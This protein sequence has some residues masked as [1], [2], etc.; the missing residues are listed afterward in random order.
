MELAEAA[1]AGLG[2]RYRPTDEVVLRAKAALALTY[3]GERRFD[4]SVALYTEV[5]A[6]RTAALGDDHPQTLAAKGNFAYILEHAGRPE[7]AARAARGSGRHGDPHLRPRASRGDQAQEQ[8]WPSAT[9]G[10]A[11]TNRPSGS[12]ANSWT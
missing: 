12:T 3:F 1:V 6:A 7:E 10:R 9:T 11:G 8:P 4:E 5:I 2:D